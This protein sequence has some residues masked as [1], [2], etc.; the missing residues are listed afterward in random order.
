M[1]EG[2]VSNVI[3]S[4]TMRLSGANF[5]LQANGFLV[6]FEQG[7]INDFLFMDNFYLSV[8]A[9]TQNKIQFR[10]GDSVE[11]EANL[12]ISRGRFKFFKPGRIQFFERGKDKALTK[13]DILLALKIYTIQ[14]GQPPKCL[15]CVHGV[16]VDHIDSGKGPTRSVVCLE[17]IADFQLCTLD[18]KSPA[19]DKRDTCINAEWQG[20]TCHHVL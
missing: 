15:H 8:S 10:K 13:A 16:L 11:F 17:G 4:L 18:I 2:I 12:N 3:P 9:L 7:Y 6:F 1:V 14:K 5:V 19:T 20:K